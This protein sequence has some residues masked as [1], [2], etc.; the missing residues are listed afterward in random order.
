MQNTINISIESSNF[1]LR[2]MIRKSI[3]REREIKEDFMKTVIQNQLL[4]LENNA[5]RKGSE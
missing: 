3:R 2:R 5:S 1:L 4:W